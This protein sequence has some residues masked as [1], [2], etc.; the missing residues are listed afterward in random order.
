MP[1]K[2]IEKKPKIQYKFIFIK[3]DDMGLRMDKIKGI[4]T[5]S[6]ESCLRL[7]HEKA[8]THALRGI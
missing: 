1:I 7:N 6:K 2:R 8:F 4:S 5:P 3:K